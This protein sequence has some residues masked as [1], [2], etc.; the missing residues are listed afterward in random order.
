MGGRTAISIPKIPS[1]AQNHQKTLIFMDNHKKGA[2]KLHGSKMCM[3]SCGN[4]SA[5]LGPARCAETTPTVV[6]TKAL[7]SQGG[8][9]LIQ[10]V[11]KFP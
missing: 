4:M 11:L 5:F 9:Q 8:K 6:L 1:P 7:F 10:Y 3:K 2:T